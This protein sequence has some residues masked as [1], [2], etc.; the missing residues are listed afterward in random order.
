MEKLS[1][2][3]FSSKVYQK[4]RQNNSLTGI[5]WELTYK[6]NLRCRH[7]YIPDKW[8]KDTTPELTLDQIKRVIDQLT[9]AGCMNILLTGGEIFCRKD[10]LDILQYL[11]D[12]CF[13]ITIQTNGTLITKEIA[14]L[15]STFSPKIG[16]S[17]SLYALSEKTYSRIVGVR[18]ALAR[19]LRG[20]EFLKKQNAPFTISM[21]VMR[22]NITEFDAVR[23]FARKN[24]IRFQ[25]DFILQPRLDHTQDVLRYRLPLSLAKELREKEGDFLKNTD[26][27]A[28]L[29]KL[30]FAKEELFYCAAGD[31]TMGINPFGKANICPDI[32]M[33]E[34]DVVKDDVSGAWQ[35][36]S[37][38]RRGLTPT[39]SYACYQC[40]VG[41][42]CMWCP[43]VALRHKNDLNACVPYY[44]KLAQLE[45]K[46]FYDTR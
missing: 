45:K 9:R 40:D 29:K 7:C 20:I 19:V 23:E 38:F 21:L 10:A 42:F 34:A 43:A 36:V 35:K 14:Q 25:Y 16:L 37:A 17:I 30:R 15:L 3:D 22:D 31:T 39:K 11:K 18:G 5:A 46:A 8:K 44:K 41:D 24:E 6:C 28:Q 4:A 33:P 32:P 2:A 27:C 1:F 12:K 13:D 26:D